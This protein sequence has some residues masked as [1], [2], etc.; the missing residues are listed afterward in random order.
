MSPP[1]SENANSDGSTPERE[2]SGK[3]SPIKVPAD[4]Q[5]NRALKDGYVEEDNED[6]AYLNCS[7]MW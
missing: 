1:R 6:I 5:E 2:T 4:K 7:L 3:P